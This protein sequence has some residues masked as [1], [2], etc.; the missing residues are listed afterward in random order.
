VRD[1]ERLGSNV[2]RL[3]RAA[4]LS[5]IE[6]ADRCGMHFTEISRL[7]RG[8]KDPQLSTIV[9]LARGLDVAPA[10]LLAGIA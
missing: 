2:R 1:Q 3:R 5:Q 8:R 9:K 6:L 4:G 7:E 10:D